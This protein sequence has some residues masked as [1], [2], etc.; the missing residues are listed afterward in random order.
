[1]ATGI[2]FVEQ[3]DV[4]LGNLRL[5]YSTPLDHSYWQDIAV[6]ADGGAVALV[7]DGTGNVGHALVGNRGDDGSRKWSRLLVP[8][9]PGQQ[10]RSVVVNHDGSR[11]AIGLSDGTV[12][13]WVP[14]DGNPGMILT[15]TSGAVRG[16]AFTSDGSHVVAVTRDGV[17]DVL[18]GCASCGDSRAL[19]ADANRVLADA[20]RMGLTKP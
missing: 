12:E 8:L 7:G 6:S 9:R 4:S 18:P 10:A 1:M 2:G 17:V 20:V 5:V 13:Y 11:G 15:E 14:R 3:T 16:L 19:T